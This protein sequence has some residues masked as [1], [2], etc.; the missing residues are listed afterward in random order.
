MACFFLAG[1]D[2]VR[3]ESAVTELN[4]DFVQGTDVYPKSVPEMMALL[5]NRRE[6][7]GKGKAP[8]SNHDGDN[9]ASFG[10]VGDKRT[11]FRCRKKGHIARDCPEKTD[12]DGGSVA[13]S[14]G[15][16][17]QRTGWNGMSVAEQALG[18]G[19]GWSEG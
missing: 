1:V 9:E 19:L 4:N 5:S 12:T 11:C 2:K 7:K 13:S 14:G 3:Y 18:G 10:Q 17:R 15:R 6:D 16:S 8:G